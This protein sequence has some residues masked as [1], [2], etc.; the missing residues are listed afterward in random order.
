VDGA[1]ERIKTS[2]G[3]AGHFLNTGSKIVKEIRRSNLSAF[4][5]IWLTDGKN[6]RDW[7]ASR[8]D[9]KCFCLVDR[10][11]RV[12]QPPANGCKPC[13]VCRRESDTFWFQV[14]N[15]IEAWV[16]KRPAR[17]AKKSLKGKFVSL[18][19]QRFATHG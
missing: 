17:R 9:A 2:P 13:R 7:L 16:A 14:G 5:L 15:L 11:C 12:A 8:G 1:I 10:W 4:P 18:V 3:S 19:A 6:E